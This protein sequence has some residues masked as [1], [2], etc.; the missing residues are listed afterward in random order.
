MIM[1]IM[2]DHDDDD[3]LNHWVISTDL[4]DQAVS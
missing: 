1:H 2:H 3:S 4:I